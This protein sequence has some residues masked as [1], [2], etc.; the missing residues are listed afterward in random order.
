M[1]C[2]QL[3]SSNLMFS[4]LLS[5]QCVAPSHIYCTIFKPFSVDKMVDF[6]MGFSA[7]S[8]FLYLW[9]CK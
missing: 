1:G 5:A 7:S 9:L 3:L 2:D 4:F 8:S 6:L